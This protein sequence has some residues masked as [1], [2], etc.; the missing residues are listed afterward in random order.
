MSYKTPEYFDSTG[1]G[2][3]NYKNLPNSASLPIDNKRA[4]GKLAEFGQFLPFKRPIPV[5]Y[6][7]YAMTVTSQSVQKCTITNELIVIHLVTDITKL[8]MLPMH[9]LYH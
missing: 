5:L 1:T 4:S 6:G 8:L 7:R 9:L 2:R 3:L